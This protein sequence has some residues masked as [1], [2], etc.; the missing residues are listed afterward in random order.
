MGSTSE[1]CQIFGEALQRA[2]P[3]LHVVVATFDRL[4]AGLVQCE[5]CP[6][7]LLV[8]RHRRQQFRSERAVVAFPGEGEDDARRFEEFAKYAA[9]PEIGALRRAHAE[10]VVATDANVGLAVNGG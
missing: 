4:K 10:A 7:A 5:L 2:G 1:C 9:F 8:E 6:A 3:A